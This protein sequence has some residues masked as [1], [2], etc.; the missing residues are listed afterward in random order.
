[1]CIRLDPQRSGMGGLKQ[2]QRGPQ[3]GLGRSRPGRG[4]TL[5][6]LVV[7]MTLASVVMTGVW[8]AWTLLLR[9]SVDPLVARQA[10]AVAQSLLREIELQPL[11]G[12]AVAGSTPGRT[13]YASINDYNG[14]VM[15][16]IRDAE[17]NAV[18]GLEGYVATVSVANLALSGVPSGSGWWVTVSVSG[19]GG[20]P[21]QLAQWR[22]AR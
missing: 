7:A 21:L 9:R 4:V 8:S 14:L 1:M 16:G 12:T 10:L 15:N 19:P 5:I 22:S 17:G 2:R 20:E 18:P 11:P 13:G 3:S 6:E